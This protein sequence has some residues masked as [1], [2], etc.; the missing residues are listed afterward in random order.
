MLQKVHR[1][2]VRCSVQIHL[3]LT[4]MTIRKRVFSG[5]DSRILEMTIE[6]KTGVSDRQ[7]S[8]TSPVVLFLRN[9][10]RRR[11]PLSHWIPRQQARGEGVEP[12]LLER[13]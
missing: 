7:Q 3:H 4:G 2:K 13:K 5:V 9:S 1:C 11:E 6:L 10:T 12:A 8:Q